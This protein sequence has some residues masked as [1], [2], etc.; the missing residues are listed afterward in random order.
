[1]SASNKS[2]MAGMTKQWLLFLTITVPAGGCR[3]A[4]QSSGQDT[5]VAGT[6]SGSPSLVAID[7]VALGEADSL[8]LSLPSSFAVSGTGEFF[9][10]D[11]GQ[12][13]VVRFSRT[14]QPLGR[15]G[16]QGSG[17][18]EYKAPTWLTLLGDSILLVKNDS[19]LRVMAFQTTS[20]RYLWERVFPGMTSS[21]YLDGDRLFVGF[22]DIARKGSVGILDLRSSSGANPSQPESL[23]VVGPLPELFARVPRATSVFGS[24][25]VAAFNDTVA[26]AYE[27]SNHLYLTHVNGREPRV[28]DSI[29]IPVVSRR[30][31]RTDLFR[32]VTDDKNSA[33]AAVYKSSIP[34]ELARLSSGRLAY[35][36][37]DPTVENRRMTGKLLLSVID[38]GNRKTCADA[39]IPAQT[40]PPARVAFRGDTVYT[41][42]QELVTA[43]RSRS[44]VRWYHLDT[45]ECQWR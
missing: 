34:F 31:S 43:D 1:M 6:R 7:S 18:G 2:L 26:S 10:A 25:E 23:N 4:R 27:V 9:V 42:S 24:V 16:R 45:R 20:G 8:Y 28:V 19:R 5:R 35:V 3:E 14:G 11:V 44:V 36:V 21:M 38:I 29:E 22:I 40:D 15:L 37:F 30:G 12:P 39:T 13:Q 33:M 41:L 32:Q 17:P